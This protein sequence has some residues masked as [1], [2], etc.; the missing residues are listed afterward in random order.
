MEEEKIER[1]IVFQVSKNITQLGPDLI[2]GLKQL[3]T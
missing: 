3:T 1:S 2:Y